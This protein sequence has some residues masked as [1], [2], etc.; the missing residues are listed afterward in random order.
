[1]GANWYKRTSPRAIPP[2]M[3]PP[4]PKRAIHRPSEDALNSPDGRALLWYGLLI[5]GDAP[6]VRRVPG[7]SDFDSSGGRL[8]RSLVKAFCRGQPESFPYCRF[9][10]TLHS[11]VP[12]D[13]SKPPGTIIAI[14]FLDRNT[15]ALFCSRDSSHLLSDST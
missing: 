5:S 8:G 9:Y 7:R 4:A 10:S 1:G 12:G 2:A 14:A 6:A 3:L 13:I 11:T 15:L